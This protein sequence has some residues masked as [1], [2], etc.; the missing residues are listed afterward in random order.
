MNDYKPADGAAEKLWNA[1]DVSPGERV[2]EGVT[3]KDFAHK[4]IKKLEDVQFYR[5]SESMRKARLSRS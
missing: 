2:A 4:L 3:P 5:L 1:A